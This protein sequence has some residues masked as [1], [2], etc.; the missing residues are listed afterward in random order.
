MF[1]I[2]KQ[3]KFKIKKKMK[4]PGQGYHQMPWADG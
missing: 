2:R 1:K 4:K 3:K